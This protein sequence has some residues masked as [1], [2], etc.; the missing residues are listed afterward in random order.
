L[1][2]TGNHWSYASVALTLSWVG[3]LSGCGASARI[4]PHR[5]SA[6]RAPRGS[7]LGVAPMQTLLDLGQLGRFTGTCT[8]DR[9]V[10]AFGTAGAATELVQLRTG[11]RRVLRR[12]VNSARPL[13]F[14]PSLMRSALPGRR[15]FPAT[16]PLLWNLSQPTEPHTLMA[17]LRM[18]VAWGGAAT[19]ECVLLRTQAHVTTR[20]H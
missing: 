16:R 10:I 15:V 19:Q 18:T 7:P 13:I 12:E 5:P 3:A 14:R 6:G 20:L 11:G 4:P 17:R 9:I 2:R 8:L 1:L